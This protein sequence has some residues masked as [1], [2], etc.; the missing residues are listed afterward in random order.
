VA[1]PAWQRGD[2]EL[3]AAWDARQTHKTAREAAKSLGIA[4]S[5][6]DSR[7]RAYMAFDAMPPGQVE[8]MEAAKLDPRTIKRGWIITNKDGEII[9]RS[10]Q[11][12]TAA[13]D[14]D[15][16]ET[17]RQAYEE[18]A[19][20]APNTLPPRP[21][22]TGECLLVIDLAD[23]HILKLCVQEET[24]YT[25]SREIA[26]HRMVEGTRELLRLS[27]GLGVGRI[28][29]VMGNDILHVDNAKATTTSGTH[30]DTAGT[31]HQG[32]RDAVAGYVKVAELCAAVAPVDLIYV[33]SNHDWVMGWA[34]AGQVA[35]WFKDHPHIHSSDYSL[36]ELH[37]KYYRFEGN[38]IGLTHGD[39]AK[40]S[41][42]E[43]LM[44]TEARSHVSEC[45]HRYWYVHHFHHKIRK[46]QGVIP[47]KREKDHIGMT[48]V[49]S[50]VKTMEGDNVMIEYVRSPSP[51]DSW[52]DRNGYV[53]R[54]AVECFVHH[55]EHGQI[56]RFTS[57]F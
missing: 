56:A 26:V 25:Y 18:L 5:T 49:N 35:T 30:Q 8:S 34:L 1:N 9:R 10:T 17:I 53:N 14:Q 6:F 47:H 32:Y 52:H 50:A 44:T 12:E 51:P 15:L 48:V 41:D 16:G 31:I 43:S 13:D 27:S 4:S 28:L 24:G 36:S 55:P 40:E 22:P 37:R 38:L 3:Q 29:L 19:A 57:W 7:I 11:W 21:A 33:P 20:D 2:P 39:G 42:L 45:L 54:Q 23:V 46:A